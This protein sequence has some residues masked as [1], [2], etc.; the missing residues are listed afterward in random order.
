[1]NTLASQLIGEKMC[2]SHPSSER[3]QRAKRARAERV[4][5]QRVLRRPTDSRPRRFVGTRTVMGR[6]HWSLARR[7]GLQRV[8]WSMEGWATEAAC[9]LRSQSLYSSL[10]LR[11]RASQL[12]TKPPSSLSCFRCPRPRRCVC[13]QRSLRSQEPRERRREVCVSEGLNGR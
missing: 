1:M 2:S 5:Q 13:N 4:A 6:V 10:A 3:T 11:S 7:L 9:S 8:Q 12:P